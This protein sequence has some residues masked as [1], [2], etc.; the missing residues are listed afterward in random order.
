M[1]RQGLR[2]I[3]IDPL[4]ENIQSVPVQNS[5]ITWQASTP[6]LGY[7]AQRKVSVMGWKYALSQS[8]FLQT[9]RRASSWRELSEP[10]YRVVPHPTTVATEPSNCLRERSPRGKQIGMT[11]FDFWTFS[12]IC[13]ILWWTCSFQLMIEC[14]IVWTGPKLTDLKKYLWHES[15]LFISIQDMLIYICLFVKTGKYIL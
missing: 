10:P 5:N 13:N 14:C 7:P 3:G 6:P 15:F 9:G 12:E 4:K 8:S 2:I 1:L 11:Y